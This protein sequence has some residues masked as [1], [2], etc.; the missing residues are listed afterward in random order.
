MVAIICVICDKSDSLMPQRNQVLNALAARCSGVVIRERQL[1]VLKPI[2]DDDGWKSLVGYFARHI[3]V[4]RRR[5][6]NRTSDPLAKK[7]LGIGFVGSFIA[8]NMHNSQ[9]EFAI[10]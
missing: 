5:P 6:Q 10:L 4:G 1:C 3:S 9:I 8:A 2:A 7:E